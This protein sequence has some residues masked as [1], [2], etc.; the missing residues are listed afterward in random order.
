[1]TRSTHASLLFA[2]AACTLVIG[3]APP[4]EEDDDY[5]ES[6]SSAIVGGSTTASFPAVGALVRFG[7]PFCTGTL[8]TKRVVVT[9]AHCIDGVPASRIGFAIGPNAFRPQVSIPA[10]RAVAHPNWNPVRITNDIGI[11]VLAADAPVA[12]I[13]LNATALDS[14]WVG[15][16][17]AFVGYGASNGFTGSGGGVKRSVVLPLSQIGATQFAYEG[18]TANTCFGD[19]GGPALAIG[20]GNVPSLVGVTSFGDQTCSQYGVDTRVDAFATFISTFTR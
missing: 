8:V 11:V 7:S 16:R 20:E 13:A 12:P 3:C 15:R 2:L 19:S 10:A 5:A 17:L 4:Q 14:S 9:A 1:M 6:S 18:R